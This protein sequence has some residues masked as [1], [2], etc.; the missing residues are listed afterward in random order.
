[1]EKYHQ[2]S[3]GVG[4]F[5]TIN[6][7]LLIINDTSLCCLHNCTKRKMLQPNKYYLMNKRISSTWLWSVLIAKNVISMLIYVLLLNLVNDGCLN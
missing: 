4:V 6:L 2:W 1:M 3:G 5:L 7:I